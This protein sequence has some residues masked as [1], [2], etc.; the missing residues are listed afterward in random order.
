M[1]FLKKHKIIITTVLIIVA[2]ILYVFVT[3]GEEEDVLTA[4]VIVEPT[5]GT[6]IEKNLVALLLDLQSIDLD[7]ALFQSQVF[8]GLI[9]FGQELAPHPIGRPNPFAPIGVDA[10]G[11]FEVS[12]E[13]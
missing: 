13:E 10:T 11:V 3:S 4:E 8:R 1:N 7:D 9:D 12:D 6:L 2:F 5:E